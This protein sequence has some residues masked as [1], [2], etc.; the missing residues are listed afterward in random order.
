[1]IKFYKIKTPKFSCSILWIDKEG[2]GPKNW[3]FWTVVLEET[4]E[5]PLDSKEIKPVKPKE[6]QFWIFLGSTDAE[7]EA[8]VLWSPDVKSQ[9]IGKY[10]MLGKIECRRKRGQQM[11]RWFD[12]IIDTMEMNMSKLW[13]IV[14][15]RKVWCAAV[16]RIS[17]SWTWLT[18]WTTALS[19][20]V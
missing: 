18:Y 16:H 4:L 10:L 11:M 8:P 6:N 7:A 12:G 20:N 19:F 9:L 13:E 5:S 3:C 2:R 1:M 17:N 15:D 14:K